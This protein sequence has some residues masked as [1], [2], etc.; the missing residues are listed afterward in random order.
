MTQKIAIFN[1]K[2]GIGKTT[3]TYNLAS[4]LLNQHKKSVL[5]LDLDPQ[6]SLTL[7]AG[8]DSEILE[9][10]LTKAISN[11]INGKEIKI[12]D[13]ILKSKSGVYMMPS[14]ILLTKVERQLAAE[15]M[16][17]FVLK[18]TLVGLETIDL[19]YIL[20]DSP[21]FLS[22]ITDN[23][24]TYA[25][26]VLIPIAADYLSW[27]A[28]ESLAGSIKE[29]QSKTNPNL[30]II[31][32]VFNIADMRTFHSKDIVKFA[33]KKLGNNIYIFNTII[34]QCTKVRE[35]QIKAESIFEYDS[36]CIG[37]ADYNSFTKEF[38][39][40]TNGKKK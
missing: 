22:L 20:I 26:S 32:I 2:G 8:F 34:R 37:F 5:A 28:F 17:E 7:C 19:D 10:T 1:S 35:A 18:R 4:F 13:Y 12:G 15:T 23:I 40:V 27:K 14:D 30:R 29:I 9:N 33:K 21:P 31:G 36:D 25:D 11:T 39:E 38:L 24:L 3:L 6:A 16:R